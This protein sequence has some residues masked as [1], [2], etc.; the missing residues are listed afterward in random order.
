MSRTGR[1]AVA[2]ALLALGLLAAACTGDDGG[3]SSS[4]TSTSA[5]NSGGAAPATTETTQAATTTTVAVPSGGTVTLGA[6]QEPDSADWIGSCAGSSWGAWT[7][8]YQTMPRAST[9]CPT[10]TVGYAPST[11]LA[12]EPKLVDHAP[13]RSSPT[14]IPG[15]GVVRRPPITSTD[16]RYTWD[17]VHNGT[18]IYD[19]SG[20]AEIESV[21]DS[22]PSIAVVTFRRPYAKWRGLFGGQYG[23]YPVPPAAG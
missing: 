13:S 10:A 1:S 20:Y 19:R 12:G 4:S 17:Q 3:D 5:T 2:V 23:I 21:D 9:L 6:E 16:F 18:D 8:S 7:M 11:L 14:S 15:G 22:V